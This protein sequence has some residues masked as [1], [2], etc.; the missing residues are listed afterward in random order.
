MQDNNG[1]RVMIDWMRPHAMAQVCAMVQ[2]EMGE[3]DKEFHSKVM[4]ITLV[5]IRD[6]TMEKD[7]ITPVEKI[8]PS[9]L[10]VIHAAVESRQTEKNR[11]KDTIRVCV[12]VG[13]AIIL[14]MISYQGQYTIIA[15]LSKL[16]SN[17]NIKFMSIMSLFWTIN[18]CSTQSIEV[19]QKC[20]LT[21]SAKSHS[22]LQEHLAKIK[23]AEASVI[24]H[25]LHKNRY[26]NIN[27]STSIFVEQ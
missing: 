23:I 7:I 12:I 25:G 24:A 16:Q 21:L 5:Y 18:G 6:W 3:L 10:Q 2:V 17:C 8:T 15:Q 27:I 13:L 9:L 11:N 4:S 20:G 1:R 14:L 22:S 19:L 26:N